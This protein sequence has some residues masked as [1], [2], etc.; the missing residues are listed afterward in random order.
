MD[1]VL[2]LGSVAIISLT[3]VL[4][5]GPVFAATVA[6]GTESRYAGAWVALG[7]LIV[8]VPM[9]LAI[10]AGFYYLFTHVWVKAGIGLVGGAMLLFMGVQMFRMRSDHEVVQKAFPYHPMVAGIITTAS[11]PYFMLWW[12]TVGATLIILALTFGPIGIIAFIVVHE[13][14]DLVWDYFVAYTVNRSKRLWTKRVH[15]IVFG[16]CGILLT[17]FGVY[18]VLAVWLA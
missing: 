15:S 7:H 11:N 4:M 12:A 9:I 13:S 2:F 1:F 3:G 18:F 5:P 16:A 8:E 10:A 17:G 14:C 6:K